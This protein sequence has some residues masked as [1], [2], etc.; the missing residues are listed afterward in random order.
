MRLIKKK[1]VLI[2]N[3][4]WYG[5]KDFPKILLE[6]QG[7]EESL[8]KISK[9]YHNGVAFL[10][11]YEKFNN[12]NFFQRNTRNQKFFLKL[13]NREIYWQNRRPGG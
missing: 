1:A 9:S 13:Q 11:F 6:E 12:N 8:A 5:S 3:E 4:P 10:Y 2:K 7:W